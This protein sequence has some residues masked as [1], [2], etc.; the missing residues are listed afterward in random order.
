MPDWSIYP[1][2]EH[3]REWL[4]ARRGLTLSLDLESTYQGQI[5]CLAMWPV[6][7][8]LADQ[9]IC[10]PFYRKGGERYWPMAA[11]LEVKRLLFGMLKDRDWPKIGQ[12]FIGFDAPLIKKVWDIT[13][14]GI[15][16]DLMVAHWQIMPEMPHGL[17]FISSMF[18]DLPPYKIE[19][20]EVASEEKDDVDK[21]EN[22]LQYEDRP[23]RVYCMEDT[24]VP[25]VTWPILERIMSDAST[26]ELPNLSLAA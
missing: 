26:L 20:H 10:I 14:E 6:E 9:G 16:A 1:D 18:T 17:A 4:T 3:V 13:V 5:M 2:V 15:I 8:A 25:A 22:V 24:F 21:W 7:D 12:N 11:D 23:L 19:V